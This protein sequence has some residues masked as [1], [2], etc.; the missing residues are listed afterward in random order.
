MP[1][2]TSKHPRLRGYRIRSQMEGQDWMRNETQTLWV[3]E[4]TLPNEWE[5]IKSDP[6]TIKAV[7]LRSGKRFATYE[8]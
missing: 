7:L 6:R 2:A 5:K 3:V 8:R 4:P 1:R